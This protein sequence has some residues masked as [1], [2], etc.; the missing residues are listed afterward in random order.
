MMEFTVG[1]RKFFWDR[2]ALWWWMAAAVLLL[3]SCSTNRLPIINLYDAGPVTGVEKQLRRNAGKWLGVPYRYGGQD[4]RGI[5]CSALIAKIYDA[6]FDVRLPRTT[7]Q[8]M[9]VGR[10][11]GHRPLTA[12]DIVFFS[13]GISGIHAGVYLGRG[14]FVHASSRKGVT[15]SSLNTRYWRRHYLAARRLI[16]AD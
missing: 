10:P 9:K 6:A 16:D 11:V 2:I 7:R 3:A 14:E 15:V 1:Y 8:Q 13:T 5:D 12:G 4:R